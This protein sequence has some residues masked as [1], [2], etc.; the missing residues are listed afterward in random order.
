MHIN[1]IIGFKLCY[2]LS[3]E[4]FYLKVLW[5]WFDLEKQHSFENLIV[6]VEKG[7]KA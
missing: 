6:L 1:F 2:I 5:L 3:L 7:W 4:R